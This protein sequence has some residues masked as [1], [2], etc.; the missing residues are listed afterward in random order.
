MGKHR[1]FQSSPIA[2]VAKGFNE[3]NTTV[4]ILH[5]Q[6]TNDKAYLLNGGLHD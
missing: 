1:G 5:T 6:Q 4:Y 2:K 3:M